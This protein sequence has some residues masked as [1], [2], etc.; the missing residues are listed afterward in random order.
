MFGKRSEN[1]LTN[2][3]N[4]KNKTSI[5]G[6]CCPAWTMEMKLVPMFGACQLGISF[7]LNE[8][9]I[10]NAYHIPTQERVVVPLP[11]FMETMDRYNI[12]IQLPCFFELIPQLDNIN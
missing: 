7:H 8:I 4:N 9:P 1:L 6:I 2:N 3:N 5:E 10:N 12:S 11:R